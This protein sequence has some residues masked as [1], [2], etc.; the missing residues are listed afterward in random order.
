MTMSLQGRSLLVVF[1]ILAD[2]PLLG[3]FRVVSLGSDG[4]GVPLAIAAI[5]SG[6]VAIAMMMGLG[7][8]RRV[9]V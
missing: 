3:A 6:L 2:V 1:V 9:P 4:G 5:G 8:V 7:V